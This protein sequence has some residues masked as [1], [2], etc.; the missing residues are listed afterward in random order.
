MSLKLNPHGNH[1][2]NFRGPDNSDS[3]DLRQDLRFCIPNKFPFNRDHNLRTKAIEDHFSCYK[4]IKNYKKKRDGGGTFI[5][6][7]NKRYV[8]Q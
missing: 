2:E 6:I 5:S 4:T 3:V 7:R 8:N 1:L